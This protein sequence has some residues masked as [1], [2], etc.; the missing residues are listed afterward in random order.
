MVVEW[1]TGD[2]YYTVCQ[3]NGE[4]ADSVIQYGSGVGNMRLTLDKH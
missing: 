2:D 4:H 3:W 1:G